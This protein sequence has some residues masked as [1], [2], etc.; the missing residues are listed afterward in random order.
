VD[1]KHSAKRGAAQRKRKYKGQHKRRRA[2]RV[3]YF[4]VP[5]PLWKRIKHLLPE[6]G[7]AGAEDDRRL[8]TVRC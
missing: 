4:R 8:A 1:K 3:D 7:K 5:K 6:Q 2:L